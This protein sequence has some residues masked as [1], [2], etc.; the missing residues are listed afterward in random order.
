MNITEYD[1]ARF[2]SKVEV[3]SKNKCWNWKKSNHQ[4][5]YGQ[6]RFNGRSQTSHRVALILYTNEINEDLFVLHS[7]DN[8]RCC[9]PYHLRWG[10]PHENTQ[11]C[12]NRGRK[13]DPPKNNTNPPVHYGEDNNK[14]ILNAEKVKEI[15]KIYQNGKF[16]QKE[17][18]KKFNVSKSTIAQV[19][20]YKTWKHVSCRKEGLCQ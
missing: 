11:D 3:G 7:C 1:R 5:G 15:R 2:W 17:L 4:F 18:S 16:T 13:T 9:N 19:V 14:S 8:P 12:I 10:T 6:F 20:N